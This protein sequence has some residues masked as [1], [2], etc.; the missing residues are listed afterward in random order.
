MA[1]GRLAFISYS[2]LD[3][4]VVEQVERNLE[5]L[6]WDTF[7]D[8]ELSGGQRWWDGILDNYRKTLLET[9]DQKK[10]IEVAYGNID[11]NK[12]DLTFQEYVLKFMKK[13]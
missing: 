13:K 1:S 10:A 7:W 5:S 9:K 8:R 3:V 6:G 12:L 4:A 2:H 11:M